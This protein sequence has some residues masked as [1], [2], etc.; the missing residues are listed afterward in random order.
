MID[1]RG[2]TVLVT[3]AS[4][5]LG[6]EFA[7][8]LAAR[9]ANLV[10]VARREDRLDALKSELES[11]HKVTVT[12]IAVDLTAP[13]AASDLADR[14]RMLGLPV[15]SLI[16][17]AGFGTHNNFGDESPAQIHNEV[18]LNVTAVVD[19]T[20]AFWPELIGHGKGVLV[21]VASAAAFQ[22]IPKMAIYGATKAF[23]LSFT[24]ALWYEAKHS[25][26]TDAGRAG[27]SADGSSSEGSSPEGSTPN[28]STSNGS[29]R[30][31]SC[32]KVLALCPGA[33]ET[34]FFDTSG[35]GARIGKAAS[36][37]AVIRLAL[38]TLDRRNPPP[39]VIHGFEN[40]VQVWSERLISRRLLVT[41]AGSLTK[42]R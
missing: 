4:A 14:V 34:E 29:A 18:T 16:N 15:H 17:N 13:G 12:P 23:V 11:Q 7:R 28:G 24:E 40:R 19:L 41:A 21:N 10:L 1:Y 9:G 31:G 36:P 32:L 37:D 25:A 39:S 6:A 3:G 8:H 22:P 26:T 42:G 2:T 20:K 5:G 35:P 30:T 27:S 38:A 33:T